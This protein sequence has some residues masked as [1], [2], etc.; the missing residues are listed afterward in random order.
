[1]SGPA[2]IGRES[3]PD[4]AA[5]LQPRRQGNTPAAAPARLGSDEGGGII[6]REQS[7]LIFE[8]VMV[9]HAK[10]DACTAHVRLRSAR[11]APRPHRRCQPEQVLAKI[12]ST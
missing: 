5:G 1:M 10:L 8:E 11:S 2:S 9:N 7:R 6:T 4:G 12:A 3:G